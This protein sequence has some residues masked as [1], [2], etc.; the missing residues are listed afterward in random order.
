MI[1]FRAL[2]FVTQDFGLPD[3]M[4]MKYSASKRAS[5]NFDNGF[6]VSV[7]FGTLYYSNGIDSYEV[8]VMRNGGV[9]YDSGITDDVISRISRYEVSEIMHKVQS[10][11]K[12]YIHPF[13]DE[14]EELS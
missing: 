1:G 6:G 4:G 5:Y 2:Q 11:P 7:L 9:C 13:K 3:G 12:G 10:L 8:A 14:D